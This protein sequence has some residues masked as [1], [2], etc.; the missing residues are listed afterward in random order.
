[1]KQPTFGSA[2]FDS[3]Q[4]HVSSVMSCFSRSAI[5][6]RHRW[7][8]HPFGFTTATPMNWSTV[9]SECCKAV[10]SIWTLSIR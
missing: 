1:M 6:E 5:S 9:P 8:I 2:S 3:L 10:P 7:T 4:Y